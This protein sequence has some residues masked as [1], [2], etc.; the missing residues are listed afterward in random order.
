[1]LLELHLLFLEVADQLLEVVVELLDLLQD[2]AR[3]VNGL[4]EQLQVGRLR[5]KRTVDVQVAA[6]EIGGFGFV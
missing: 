4:L 3:G 2:L 6:N 1:M 5:E